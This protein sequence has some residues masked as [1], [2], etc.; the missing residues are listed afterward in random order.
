[1]FTTT[2]RNP[3]MYYS[4]F[5]LA[6]YYKNNPHR[7]Q[8]LHS[9]ESKTT[10]PQIIYRK[11]RII[12]LNKQ[13]GYQW[14]LD[15][16]V[17]LQPYLQN[18]MLYSAYEPDLKFGFFKDGKWYMEKEPQFTDENR[19]VTSEQFSVKNNYVVLHDVEANELAYSL[20]N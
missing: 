6:L 16:V 10:L 11:T 1:M 7:C 4:S 3:F 13:Y 19:I 12:T 9:I 8:P 17:D 14:C 2:P 20:K 15:K 18:A 5:K